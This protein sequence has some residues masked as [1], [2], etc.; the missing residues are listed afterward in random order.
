MS[1]YAIQLIIIITSFLVAI[2]IHEFAHVWVTYLLGS[3][4]MKKIYSK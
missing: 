2:T 3:V 1:A 4:N